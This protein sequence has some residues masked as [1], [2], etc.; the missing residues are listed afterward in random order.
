[1]VDAQDGHRTVTWPANPFDFANY[2]S[3]T[4]GT[5]NLHE[6]TL[7][8]NMYMHVDVT[9]RTITYKGRSLYTLKFWWLALI[10]K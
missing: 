3:N 10:M 8:Y 9:A 1:M 5:K 4:T 6:V 7:S 2:T